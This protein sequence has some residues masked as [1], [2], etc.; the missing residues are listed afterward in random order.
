MAGLSAQTSD[1]RWKPGK[2]HFARP[3][4]AQVDNLIFQSPSRSPSPLQAF[5][6]RIH[7]KDKSTMKS[8]PAVR[9]SESYTK[10]HFFSIAAC[11]TSSV[12][13]SRSWWQSRGAWQRP[14]TWTQSAGTGTTTPTTTTSWKDHASPSLLWVPLRKRNIFYLVCLADI[15]IWKTFPCCRGKE[16]SHFFPCPCNQTSFSEISHNSYSKLGRANWARDWNRDLFR[17]KKEA[18]FQ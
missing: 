7:K 10:I 9:A 6:K 3:R 1:A 16:E 4:K 18:D 11:T 8:P 2:G 12:G 17:D 15:P 13:V 5:H 14:S